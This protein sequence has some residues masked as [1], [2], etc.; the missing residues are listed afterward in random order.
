MP[1][2]TLNHDG[3]LPPG[4]WDCPLAE[5]RERFGIFSGSDQRARLFA[6]LDDMFQTMQRSGL[7]EALLV[8]GS[9]VTAKPAPNDIDLVAVLLPG[10]NFE[11][12]L[13]MSEYALVSRALLR[14]RYGFDVVIAEKGS[15]LCKTYIE[16]FSRVRDSPSVSKGMLRLS[17]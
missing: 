17:L 1:I 16:F 3:F 10:H 4:I 13:P 5:L 15:Q 7:F 14:R 6:R 2:P 11:R 9:Y 8:D 12:D